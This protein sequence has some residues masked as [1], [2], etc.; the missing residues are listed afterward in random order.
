MHAA[1]EALS[2]TPHPYS[3]IR[4]YPIAHASP[5][6]RFSRPVTRSDSYTSEQA[7]HRPGV[8]PVGLTHN[9]DPPVDNWETPSGPGNFRPF[10]PPHT[11]EDE[12][13]E[14]QLPSAMSLIP[15]QRSREPEY[16]DDAIV[17]RSN[18]ETPDIPSV[19]STSGSLEDTRGE[20]E[21]DEE[22]VLFAS[23]PLSSRMLVRA[24][25][26]AGPWEAARFVVPAVVMDHSWAIRFSRGKSNI[27]FPFQYRPTVANTAKAWIEHVVREPIAWWPLSPRREPLPEDSVRVEWQCVSRSSSALLISDSMCVG[28]WQDSFHHRLHGTQDAIPPVD[29]R[30]RRHVARTEQAHPSS[31]GDW[32]ECPDPEC[33]QNRACDT[34]PGRSMGDVEF[35]QYPADSRRSKARTAQDTH[36]V[37]Q[38]EHQIDDCD[39]SRGAQ[40][41]RGH[42]PRPR[43]TVP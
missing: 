20:R 43:D 4:P 36:V 34:A 28:L 2:D 15:V 17:G 37:H 10:L 31:A 11:L 24:S 16:T 40:D 13:P 6:A 21:I 42:L 38:L 1:A 35:T 26:T 41:R 12:S 19:T 9:Q 30:R 7:V 8:S 29:H 3:I 23:L 14:S 25:T 33:I 5:I 27:V 18:Q 39:Q 22:F 32:H